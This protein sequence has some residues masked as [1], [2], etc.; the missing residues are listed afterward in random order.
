MRQVVGF[1]NRSTGR[2]YFG[3]NMGRPIV[4]NGGLS[5]LEIPIAPMRDCG[6]VNSEKCKRVGRASRVGLGLAR[7]WLAG[8]ATRHSCRMTVGRLVYFILISNVD[9]RRTGQ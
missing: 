2:G 8:A 7:V 3:E 5:L 4:T 1:E 6:L 9:F